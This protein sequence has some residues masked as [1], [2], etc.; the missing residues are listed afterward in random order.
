[1]RSRIFLTIHCLYFL[2]IG[3]PFI[4]DIADASSLSVY[5]DNLRMAS[6]DRLSTFTI[7]AVGADPKDITVT[8]TGSEGLYSF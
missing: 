7:H 1:M 8:I 4:L 2:N 6:V 5:G 3:S